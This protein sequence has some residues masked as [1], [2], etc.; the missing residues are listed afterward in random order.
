[1]NQTALEKSLQAID[2]L[3]RHPQGLS[4]A[5]MSDRLGFP[6]STIHRILKTFMA[7]DYVSQD[8]EDRKYSLGFRFLTIGSIILGNLDVRRTAGKYLYYFLFLQNS[9]GFL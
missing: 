4:L 6:K 9:V 7:Y 8:R 2:L 5:E 3:S 1:M